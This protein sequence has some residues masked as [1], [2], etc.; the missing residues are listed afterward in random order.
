[1][2]SE[3]HICK[4]AHKFGNLIYV[5]DKPNPEQLLALK[6]YILGLRKMPS[7]PKLFKKGDKKINHFLKKSSFKP[8]T[9]RKGKECEEI[10]K[11]E[12]TLED[13]IAQKKLTKGLEIYY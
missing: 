7:K 6:E 3:S 4:E 10:D 13:I 12:D 2:T 11:N 8:S 5:E 1:M 9:S